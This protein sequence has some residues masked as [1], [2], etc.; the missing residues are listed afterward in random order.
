MR[1]LERDPEKRLSASEALDHPWLNEGGINSVPGNG[2][3]ALFSDSIVQRL[4]RFGTYGVLKQT[5]MRSV[6]TSV[7]A[8]NE[9]MKELQV[10]TTS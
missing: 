9:L 7:A 8:D 4:Q 1:M 10:R 3:G 6:L 5:V 2:D